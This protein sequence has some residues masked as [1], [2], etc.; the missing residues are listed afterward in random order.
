MPTN[1]MNRRAQARGAA[2]VDPFLLDRRK[3]RLGFERAAE[4]Y[5]ANA[6]FYSVKLASV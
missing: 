1:Q 6:F 3:T 4:T 5:D 2:A